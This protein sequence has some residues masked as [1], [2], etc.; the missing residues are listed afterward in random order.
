VRKREKKR[1]TRKK[2]APSRRGADFIGGVLERYASRVPWVLSVFYLLFMGYLTF[3]Y[4][5]IGGFG[6]ETDFYVE[7]VPQAKKLLAGDFSPLNYGA[8][9]PVYSLLLAAVYAVVRDYFNAGLVL[10]L[11]SG[12]AFLVAAYHLI[13]TVFDTET[14]FLAALAILFNS[15]FLAFTYQAASDLPFMMLCALSMFFLFRGREYPNVALSAFFGLTAFL[16]RY[17][18]AFLAAGSI[19]YLALDSGSMRERFGRACL[20]AGVF[21]LAGL[22]WFIP[23]WLATG[24]PVHN[25]NYMNVMLEFYGLGREGVTYENWTD[26]LPKE[27]TGMADIILYDPVY[28]AKHVLHN[29]GTH[30]AADLRG[31]LGLRLGI[32]VLT[33]LVLAWFSGLDRKRAA[34]FSFGLFYF[35]ILTLVFYNVR[36]SLYLLVFYIPLAIWPF[37]SGP[38]IGRI[39]GFGR[40]HAAVL[41][42]TVVATYMYTS[43]SAVY[44]QLRRSPVILEDLRDLGL[45]LNEIEPDKTKRVI[46]RKPHVAYFAGLEAVMFPPH[47]RSV[48][49]LVRYCRE[50]GV[51]YVVY[52]GIEAGY[53]PDVRALL[54]VRRKHPGLEVVYYNDFGVIYR[55][56]GGD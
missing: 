25:D 5:K 46:A 12:A 4:H 15:T 30:F 28:F 14:A 51:D 41:L 53:R 54:A 49:E 29:I 17:N 8:K 11:L 40:V 2:S 43:P 38:H 44:G 47:V 24:N 23:N 52:S 56:L 48:G 45:H 34:F 36:F 18:G 26:A 19:L 20:W 3:R 37:L 16:T 39:R 22:P 33:G 35:L 21:V 27:F 42:T 7:L 10:N 13:R 1:N 32:F 55:V 31:L 50:N 6:V 9:G